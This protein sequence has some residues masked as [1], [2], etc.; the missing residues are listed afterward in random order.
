MATKNL[1]P[2]T[3]SL[4]NP[5]HLFTTTIVEAYGPSFLHWNTSSSKPPASSI[6]QAQTPKDVDQDIIWTHKTEKDLIK[7][8]KC[9]HL[10]TKHL[11]A[12]W[13]RS[14]PRHPHLA[15]LC[16]PDPN[17]YTDKYPIPK[18]VEIVPTQS[19]VISLHTTSFYKQIDGGLFQKLEATTSNHYHGASI[20]FLHSSPPDV[21][22]LEDPCLTSRLCTITHRQP[23]VQPLATT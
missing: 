7:Q 14:L 1:S 2:I 9:D 19:D 17:T 5:H 11:W 12:H 20:L 23:L 3:S 10:Q 4:Y 6:D 15:P 18:S 21:A 13:Y 16:E 8:Q 22:E